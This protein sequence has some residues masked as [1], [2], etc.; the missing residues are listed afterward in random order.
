MVCTFWHAEKSEVPKQ[1]TMLKTTL[2]YHHLVN[3]QCKKFAWKSPDEPNWNGISRL[4][5]LC[6]NSTY[7]TIKCNS[8]QKCS[9]KSFYVQHKMHSEHFTGFCLLNIT[10]IFRGVPT[11]RTYG[12]REVVEWWHQDRNSISGDKTYLIRRRNQEGSTFRPDL[13]CLMIPVFT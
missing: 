13:M 12:T 2:L 3:A 1:I 11:I 6:P 7:H 4:E 5:P 10:T 8:S 9:G